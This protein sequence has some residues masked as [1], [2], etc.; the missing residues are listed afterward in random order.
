MLLLDKALSAVDRVCNAPKRA[1]LGCSPAE[2]PGLCA[3]P[4]ATGVESLAPAQ[5]QQ[6]RRRQHHGCV[7]LT[8]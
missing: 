3:Q 2:D 8:R 1:I 4:G 7:I 6:T 5:D